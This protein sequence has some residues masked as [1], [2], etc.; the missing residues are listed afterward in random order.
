MYPL[1]KFLKRNER[2][3]NYNPRFN[4]GGGELMGKYIVEIV[5][6]G[7][8][9]MIFI[10]SSKRP[11]IAIDHDKSNNYAAV[12]NTVHYDQ[13][14]TVDGKMKRGSGT[15]EMVNFALDL[16][17]KRGVKKVQLTDKSKIDCNGTEVDLKLMHFFKYGETWYEKNFGFKPEAKYQTK[18]EEVKKRRLEKLDV[19]LLKN[20]PCD[21]FT[22]DLLDDILV[23][24]TKFSFHGNI[25]WEKIL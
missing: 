9:E 13:S 25:V 6:E 14:C 20:A 22:D 17:K 16:L 23:P 15:K 1:L 18:Y 3:S 8:Y 11:C 5:D 24:K 2:W 10:L 7:E 12:L 19:E 21:E 4:G